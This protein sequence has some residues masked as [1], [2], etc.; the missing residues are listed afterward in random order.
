MSKTA[1]LYP[2]FHVTI[3]EL[4]HIKG[5]QYIFSC[6]FLL[7]FPFL[8]VYTSAQVEDLEQYYK[9]YANTPIK[10]VYQQ[11]MDY[12]KQGETDKA[13]ACLTVITSRNYDKMDDEERKIYDYALNNAGAIAQMRSDYLMAFSLFTK[14]LDSADDSVAYRTHNNIAGIYIYYNDYANARKHLGLAYDIGVRQQDWSSV[15][16]TVH[17]ILDLNW[18]MDSLHNSMSLIEDFR[19]L[20]I[21]R[22]DSNY[23]FISHLGNG[24]ESLYLNRYP[25]AVGHFT[26][27]INAASD[28][29]FKEN[30]EVPS[31]MY[32]AKAYMKMGDYNAA[33]SNLRICENLSLENN[34][35]DLL[36]T[37]Y[38]YMYLCHIRSGNLS[39]AHAAK[40][41]YMELKDSISNA[42]EYGK[43]KDMEFFYES[44]KYEKQLHQLTSEK[45]LRGTIL[46]AI[47]IGL[48]LTL[49]FLALTIFQNKK[50]SENNKD[51]FKKNVALIKYQEY[52][53]RL[54]LEKTKEDNNSKIAE[55]E[56]YK[57]SCLS[58]EGKEMLLARIRRVMRT[59]SEFCQDDF[60]IDKLAMLVNSN[61][62]YV[63][64]VINEKLGKNFNTLLNEQRINEVCKRLVDTANNGNK[65]N[66][67]IA[68]EVGFKSRSH[69]IRT[70]KKVTGLTPT[71]YQR[72]AKE[73][74][75]ASSSIVEQIPPLS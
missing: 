13:L 34:A 19:Q 64:Q 70:F 47:G 63:S 28:L 58:D 60:T 42:N 4:A 55:S 3:Q 8:S 62:K 74:D 53:E 7:F 61:T 25:E 37:T 45:K 73:E 38:R 26:R 46:W 33:L 27:A 5:I 39:A 43:I 29:P 21:A 15:Y 36:I 52:A 51:L 14:A 20:Q 12:L 56:R 40:Y 35:L 11:G 16:N 69:F 9:W 32:S 10:S 30:Y 22:K 18:D 71:Q 49:L 59:P 68:E 57:S 75:M 44:N 54:E 72:M 31:Y 1:R 41:R 66:D 6:L 2:I 65:T 67:A 48:L 50:L 23:M 17:N 24:M